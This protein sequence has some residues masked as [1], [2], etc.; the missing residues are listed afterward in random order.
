[1]EPTRNSTYDSALKKAMD[2][3]AKRER[4]ES[5]IRRRLGKEPLEESELDAIVQELR[6]QGF[7]DHERYARSF[8]ADKFNLARWG[9]LKIRHALLET[10]V[11]AELVDR[12][13]E[14]IPEAE[15]HQAVRELILKRTEGHIP[16]GKEW[17]KVIR[18]LAGRG[19][20]PEIVREIG[21]KI[22]T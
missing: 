14:T 21:S 17:E 22:K 1:M 5:E 7:L 18:W 12:A 11:E 20:E 8:V 4:C 10:G 16:E 6:D 13:I 3:C 2:Y 19:F 15:Y 9:R